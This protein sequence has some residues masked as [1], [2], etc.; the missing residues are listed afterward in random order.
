MPRS[1]SAAGEHKTPLKRAKVTGLSS[2]VAFA[3]AERAASSAI[4]NSVRIFPPWSGSRAFYDTIVLA[5]AVAPARC[6]HGAAARAPYMMLPVPR[7]ALI[8]PLP[9]R[10]S[11]AAVAR[12]S[13][14]I[15]NW[16]MLTAERP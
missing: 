5:Q 7:L 8:T 1:E 14:T 6:E 15:S 16:M 10:P 11:I 4:G 13:S 2:A 3:G 12:G 9:F